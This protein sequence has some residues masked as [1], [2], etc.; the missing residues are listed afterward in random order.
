MYVKG[1]E[2]EEEEETPVRLRLNWSLS[3]S[4]ISTL[5]HLKSKNYSTL[6]I[7]VKKNLLHLE[8]VCQKITLNCFNM[9]Q[10]KSPPWNLF[11]TDRIHFDDKKERERVSSLSHLHNLSV[12]LASCQIATYFLGTVWKVL[13]A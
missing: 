13:K 11:Q 5:L 1:W 7:F 9:F 10:A 8:Y 12:F 3:I 6:S 2:E 4:P